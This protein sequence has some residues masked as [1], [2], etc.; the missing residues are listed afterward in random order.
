MLAAA[1]NKSSVDTGGSSGSGEESGEDP[2]E[3][4]DPRPP[5]PECL[6]TFPGDDTK[7]P[8]INRQPT[9]YTMNI[10]TSCVFIAKDGT[11]LKPEEVPSAG[12]MRSNIRTTVFKHAWM[13]SLA[14]DLLVYWYILVTKTVPNHTF[15][16]KIR[17]QDGSWA[18]FPEAFVESITKATNVDEAV[19]IIGAHIKNG[20]FDYIGA[21][22]NMLNIE[23]FSMRKR[24]AAADAA[25][26]QPAV[27][28]KRGDGFV[29]GV[30]EELSA[31]GR[32]L[33]SDETAQ[34]ADAAFF[35]HM[36][37]FLRIALTKPTAVPAHCLSSLSAAI[38]GR[39]I[40][41]VKQVLK[42]INEH[43]AAAQ[44]V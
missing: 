4:E 43:A 37:V 14:G 36:D 25:P 18:R 5:K 31:F 21:D 2:R 12:K 15:G 26:K 1:C 42:V 39:G 7:F 22:K 44:S 24:T 33:R 6:A 38:K 20:A 35:D 41:A 32:M 27:K 13:A 11:P 10:R 8:N 23:K 16:F 34:D 29:A 19:P 40:D 30:I 3:D 9:G 17:R 28:R